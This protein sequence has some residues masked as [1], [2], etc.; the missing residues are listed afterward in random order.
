MGAT[1]P[2]RALGRMNGA[3]FYFEGA[4]EWVWMAAGIWRPDTYQ[5]QLVREHIVANQPRFEGI[6]F[7]GASRRSAD[8]R[9]IN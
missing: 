7:S 2:N 8:C 5:L 1:F 6:V 3:C 4:G 9:A